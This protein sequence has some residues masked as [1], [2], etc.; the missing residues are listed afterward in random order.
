MRR[1]PV[2]PGGRR[3]R[4]RAPATARRGARC[5]PRR[6]RARSAAAW[7]R[8]SGVRSGDMGKGAFP[9]RRRPTPRGCA[10]PCQAP[11]RPGAPRT[12]ERAARCP[13]GAA[14]DDDLLLAPPRRSSPRPRAAARARACSGPSGPRR[15][16]DDLGPQAARRSRSSVASAPMHRAMHDQQHAA[17]P[18]VAGASASSGRAARGRRARRPRRARRRGP[19]ARRS[20]RG[21]RA[22][23]RRSRRSARRA[24]G[25][26]QVAAHA[27][28]RARR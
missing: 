14:H 24:T 23:W 19:A 26:E 20:R 10:Q 11:G 8:C 22:G 15:R 2:R 25:V 27:R 16:R 1:R 9:G 3:R 5:L 13:P 21:R 4:G 17:R 28:A 7:A 6:A 12:A 18:Q